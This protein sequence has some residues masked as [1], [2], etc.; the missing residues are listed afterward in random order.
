MTAGVP[1][2]ANR[3]AWAKRENCA[4]LGFTGRKVSKVAAGE[5]APGTTPM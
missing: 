2:A 5:I 3:T 4:R 1:F